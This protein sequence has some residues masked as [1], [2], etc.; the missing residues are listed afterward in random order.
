[1]YEE[2]HYFYSKTTKKNVHILVFVLGYLSLLVSETC[3]PW[4]HA[5][6]NQSA[7]VK[8]G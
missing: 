8:S 4:D 7:L 1:M 2:E 5:L 6:C 3:D